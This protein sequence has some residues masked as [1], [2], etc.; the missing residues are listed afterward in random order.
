MQFLD[1]AYARKVPGWV[2][3]FVLDLE[4]Q[5]ENESLITE[6]AQGMMSDRAEVAQYLWLQKWAVSPYTGSG[7]NLRVIP[8]ED[9]ADYL[10]VD[11]DGDFYCLKDY[12]TSRRAFFARQ[13]A[14]A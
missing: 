12:V 6:A 7:N 3:R 4:R 2:D 14:A 11:D 5:Q 9:A 10:G 8:F 13:T 1:Q